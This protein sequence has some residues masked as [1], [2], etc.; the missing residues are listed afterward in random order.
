MYVTL[1]L[2][3]ILFVCPSIYLHVT[4]SETLNGFIL[5]LASDEGRRSPINIVTRLQAGRPV[6]D[7]RHSQ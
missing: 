7:A 5:N 6:F 4:P 3:E 1:A 2:N